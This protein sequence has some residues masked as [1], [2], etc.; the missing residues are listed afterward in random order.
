M[1]PWPGAAGL[2]LTG[3]LEEDGALFFR[4]RVTRPGV[5]PVA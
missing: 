5:G 3:L 1:L 4:Y 2:A